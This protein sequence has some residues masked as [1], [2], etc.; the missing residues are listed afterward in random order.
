[1]KITIKDFLTNNGKGARPATDK[2]V[3]DFINKSVSAKYLYDEELLPKFL[4]TYFEWIQNSKLNNLR[5]LEKFSALDYVHGTSQ[6]FDFFYLR[7]HNRRFRC[8]KGDFAYHKV[9]WKTNFEWNYI[10]DD[11]LKSNDAVVVSLPFSDYG[12]KHPQMDDLM[13]KCCELNIPVFIDA[14]YYCI[15]RDVDFD[16]D[17]PCIDT[18]AFSMSKAF[19]GTERLRIGIRCRREREDD[20]AVLINDFHQISKISAGVGLEICNNF[21]TDYAQNRFREDQIRVCKILGIEPSNCVLFGLAEKDH[22]DFQDFDRGTEWRR[23]C[24][25]HLIGNCK[26]FEI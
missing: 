10:E 15:A 21:E 22:P 20:G 23:V 16:L 4:K 3:I 11:D 8:F 5:G 9:S 12:S 1:M 24:L 19:Y 6:A 17:L 25:S 26:E 7:Y 2:T 18:V 14:A 13:K